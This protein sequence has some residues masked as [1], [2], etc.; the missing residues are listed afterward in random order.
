M[1]LDFH[2]APLRPYNTVSQDGI[3]YC[4]MKNWEG[5]S[6]DKN[7]GGLNINGFSTEANITLLEF[8]NGG[9]AP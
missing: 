9:I 8:D 4:E 6:Y 3:L 1:L 2:S 7:M 5:A